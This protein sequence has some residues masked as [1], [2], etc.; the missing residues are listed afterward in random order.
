MGSIQHRLEQSASRHLDIINERKIS[1][2]RHNSVVVEKL[3]TAR[4]LQDEK[5]EKNIEAYE[6]N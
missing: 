6:E 2:E 3:A 5:M 4:K 1:L